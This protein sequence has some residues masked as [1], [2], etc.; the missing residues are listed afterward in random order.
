MV[1]SFSVNTTEEMWSN[2]I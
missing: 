2:H 1:N